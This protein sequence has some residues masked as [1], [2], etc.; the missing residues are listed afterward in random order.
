M[1][2]EK[3]LP[4]DGFAGTLIARAWLPTSSNNAVAGPAPVWLSQ[5][6]VYDLSN[7]APT[8]SALIEKSITKAD[9]EDMAL[10]YLGSVEALFNNSLDKPLD[11]SY[12][13]LLSPFDLQ[14][15]KACGVTFVG[16]MLERVIEE[17]AGGDPHVA[18]TIRDKI[19]HTLGTSVDNL[20]PGSVAAEELKR[21]LIKE[22]MW[23]QYL[24]VGIGPYAEVFTKAQPLSSVGFGAEIGIHPISTWNNPEPEIV[25]AINSRGKIVGAT[26]GNDV[27]LRD[28][29]GR[30]ALLLGKAKDNN[31]SCAI[32]PIIR[33]F[34]NTFTLTQL[35][36]AQ[37]KLSV[38][39]IQ[40]DYQLNATNDMTKISRDIEDLVSQT[41]SDCHQ[42]PDGLAL[43]TGT[44]FTPTQD[45]DEKDKGFTHKPGD[46]VSI[47]AQKLGSLVNT[48]H[49]SNEIPP[50]EFGISVLMNNLAQRNLI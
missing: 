15:I 28:I 49:F 45:R 3:Y 44:L 2:I 38:S 20:V 12:L 24:E 39:G 29:E 4:E 18:K 21:V 9:L 19:T 30:S 1:N 31:A 27:N 10:P 33:L 41:I 5:S 48:V 11:K 32:G 26:L 35:K 14:A 37:V 42:Y 22:N 13:H 43:F 36:S 34:D 8:C 47:S 40:D 17:K 6:G 25:L 50:W 23:S 46:I 16:S 7:L